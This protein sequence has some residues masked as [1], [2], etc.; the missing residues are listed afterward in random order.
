M[1]IGIPEFHE[2]KDLFNY[3]KSHKKELI[4][5][6]RSMPIT[7]DAVSFG[8]SRV[9]TT[10]TA[11]K[12]NEA[13]TEDVDVLRVKVVANTAN[14]LDSHMDVLI[15]GC[16]SKTIQERKHLIP[17][18]HDHV[19]RLDAKIGEVV[20]I[21][22]S[23]LSYSELGIDGS[24]TTESLIFVTDV[25]KEYN[26][27]VFNQYK[28]GKVKQHSIGLQYMK[29]DLAINDEDNEKEMEFWNKYYPQIINKEMADERGFFWVIQEIKLL[30]NSAV[31]FGS[32]EATPTLEN[33]VKNLSNTDNEPLNS[34]QNTET[35]A[36]KALHENQVQFYLNT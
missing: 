35:E 14:Y 12:S 3:L 21:Y 6:K 4:A 25:M 17:H 9:K 32:N 5:K 11:N 16:W 2:K 36:A 8:F 22:A 24:G 15:P 33:N 10:D 29:I 19:H 20:D 7:A 31:L 1:R 18:L 28:A 30:E 34:T 27:K 13:V 26:P 23:S